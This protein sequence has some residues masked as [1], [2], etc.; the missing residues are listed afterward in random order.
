MYKIERI[1]G[2]IFI[3]ILVSG[4]TLNCY[5]E[6]KQNINFTESMQQSVESF[7]EDRMSDGKFPGAAVVIVE[8]DKAVYKKGFGFADVENKKPVTEN[9][10]FELGSTSK[11]FTGLAIQKLNAEG[12]IN[13]D[14]PVRKY[15][16]WLKFE[17]KDSEVDVTIEQFLHQTSGVPFK[18]IGKIPEASDDNA[19]MNTVK[20]LVGTELD[21]KPGTLFSY[22]TINYDVLGLVIQN[23]THKP[24]ETYIRENVLKPLGLNGTYLPSES[25]KKD[26]MAKGYKIGFLGAR[27]YSAPTYR[28][29]TPA[30]YFITNINDMEK[31]IKIQLGTEKIP[32]TYGELVEKSHI[33][34]RT[35]KPGGDGSSYAS[36]WMVYQDG[37][38]EISHGGY[39]PNYSSFIVLRPAEK[40][41]VAVLTNLDSDYTASFG[42][43]IMDLIMGKE[44]KTQKSDTYQGMDSTAV[45][46]MCIALPFLLLTLVFILI[47]IVELVKGKRKY[48]PIGKKSFSGLAAFVIFI[49]GFGYCLLNIPDILFGGLNWDF[50]RV[51]GPGSLVPA[52]VLLLTSVLVFCFYFAFTSVFRKDE[53]NTFFPLIILSVASGFGNALIIFV[54]NAAIGRNSS[55]FEKGLF[56]YFVLGIIVYV[57]GQR[58]VRLRLVTLTNDIVYRKRVEL[59]NNIIK[60]PFYRLEALESGTIPAGLNNDTETM[61]GFANTIITGA[62]SF[63][64]L[65]S[66]FA[67]LGIINIYGLAITFLVFVVAAGL[68]YMVGRYANKLGE[69]TRDIQN[70]FFK[71]I[72]DLVSG[73]KELSINRRK[74]EDFKED[75]LRSCDNYRKKRVLGDLA[76]ANV[77]VIGEL[78]FVIVLGA[79]AFIF[80]VLFKD[81]KNSTL[82]SFVFVFIYMI[83]PVRSILAAIPDAIRMKISWQRINRLTEQIAAFKMS[84]GQLSEGYCRDKEIKLVLK[85]V[86]YSYQQEGADVFT[87]GPVNCS[88]KSG[89][90]TFI[91]GGNGSGKSTLVK[92]ITGL[93]M[94]MKG[95]IQINGNEVGGINLGEHYSSVFSD[96]YLFD[97]LYGIDIKGKEGIVLEYLKK[98]QLDK[99]VEI[100][101]KAFSTTKLSSG[102]RKRL[103]LM[104]S[105]LED[106]PIYIFDEWAADQDPEFRRFFYN[107]LLPELKHKGKCVI[108]ITHD[109]RYFGLADKVIKMET[110]KI[111]KIEDSAKTEALPEGQD[112]NMALG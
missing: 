37:K 47:S 14:D 49:G 61:S 67:Y 97:K 33:P 19:L 90:I 80:P 76:F 30:G 7:I 71:F 81:I 98:L 92:L 56:T 18:S 13:L 45:A 78:L 53:E 100:R 10:L 32:E 12:L 24:Y 5:A 63:V 104:L 3:I 50:L 4:I 23:V 77:F 83:G 52:V 74:H 102:Q 58:L 31:W 79:I 2:V 85:D 34:D 101:D 8:N 55:E 103:A 60:A 70:I 66:C 69:Q 99:K 11:A 46:V 96:Y 9:T 17:Y 21:S 73:I 6:E 41:G 75:M 15:I 20:T 43:G 107:D 48:V 87:V 109:D 44:L 82:A 27:E 40:L 84:D 62:T 88:F 51:W 89:E 64:T 26:D 1:W 95:E 110:G 68:Y 59:I 57:Y 29:N 38:G 106:R 112:L 39:N 72:N 54:I 93:Y 16:P 86:A 42:Q 28:G 22:A 111:V 35:V 36:G 108:A 25:F 91:T 65:L 105:Y 94:P